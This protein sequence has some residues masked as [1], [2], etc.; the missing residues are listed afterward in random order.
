MITKTR[1]HWM[2]KISNICTVDYSFMRG[3]EDCTA[4]HYSSS[5]SVMLK[6]FRYT[7]VFSSSHSDFCFN[8]RQCI[9]LDVAYFATGCAKNKC[10]SS[11]LFFFKGFDEC[12]SPHVGNTTA[13]SK[14]RPFLLSPSKKKKNLKGWTVTNTFREKE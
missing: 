8:N 5:Y 12:P 9:T 14:S 7:C 6:Y 4:H 3:W 2:V 1:Q 10:S 11:Y 13:Q